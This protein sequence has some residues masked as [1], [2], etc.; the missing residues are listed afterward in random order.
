MNSNDTYKIDIS[1]NIVFANYY[2]V[3]KILGTSK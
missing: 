2:I 1:E 3:T